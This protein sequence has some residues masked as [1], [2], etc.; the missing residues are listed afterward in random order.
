V[1]TKDG[2]CIVT[3]VVIV[4]PTQMNLFFQSCTTERFIAL[5]AIQVKEKNY[6]N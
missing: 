1:V 6:C 4:D 2:I 3:N 5:D